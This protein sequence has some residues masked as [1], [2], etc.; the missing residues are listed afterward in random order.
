MVNGEWAISNEPLS[1]ITNFSTIN[2]NNQHIN[3][4]VPI[5]DF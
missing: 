2:L 5:F 1:G 4:Q 3:E